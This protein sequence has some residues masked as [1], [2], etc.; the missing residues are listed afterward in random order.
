MIKPYLFRGWAG[1]AGAVLLCAP[2]LAQAPP[3]L[4][5]GE[6][7]RLALAN[8]QELQ[9]A[10]AA[11]EAAQGATLQAGLRPNPILSIQSE[12]WRAWGDPSFRPLAEVDFFTFVSQTIE[13]NGKRRKRTDLAEFQGREA[14]LARDV[15]SWRIEQ[16]VAEA[17]WSALSAERRLELLEASRQTVEE[18][19]R[20]HETR[21]EFGAIAEI[22]LIKVQVE[23]QKLAQAVA[24]AGNRLEQARLAL[25]AAMGQPR[26]DAGA[27]LEGELAPP[28]DGELDVDWFERAL[29]ERPDQALQRA[30]VQSFH[31]AV[32]LAEAQR[33][34]DLT[35][36][37]GYKRSNDFNTVVGGVN[38]PLAVNDRNQG[39]IAETRAMV[40]EEEANLRALTART[41]A[42]VEAALA[43]ARNARARLQQLEFGL[44]ERARE[45]YRI[46]RAAYQEQGTDLLFLL[47]AQR[48]Q[49]DAE[50]LL[51]Q[52]LADYRLSVARLQSVSGGL[53]LA[54]QEDRP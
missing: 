3:R 10:S 21:L 39:R 30:R 9:A 42:E 29:A 11:A 43:A 4:P 48:A 5:L 12:N 28:A 22:E 35:P 2:A 51:A 25:A 13:T 20:Y 26:L 33:K 18:L 49:N 34:P 19:V 16:Q 44:V 8:R 36:Y 40:R 24:E 15:L 1:L 47:D 17:W 41:E 31:A 27:A 38:I 54:A 50:Q 23:E 14:E 46:A 52:A 53:G 37:V 6:A 45:S 7:V 32:A